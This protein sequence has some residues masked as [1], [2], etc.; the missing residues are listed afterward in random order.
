LNGKYDEARRDMNR[1]M[2]IAPQFAEVYVS[3]GTYI[4][5]RKTDPKKA[6]EAFDRALKYS[7]EY[8]L[9]LNGKGGMETITGDLNTAAEHLQQAKDISINCLSGLSA[10]V[11]LNIAV[12]GTKINEDMD[13]RIAKATGI[14][15]GMT[16]DEKMQ[17]F[18]SL[19]L[20][21]KQAVIDSAANAANFNRTRLG[22]I[23][24][25][26]SFKTKSQLNG[27][28]GFKGTVPFGKIGGSTGIEIYTD[29]SGKTSYNVKNQEDFLKSAQQKYGLSPS[30][31]YNSFGNDIKSFI[32]NQIG[33]GSDFSHSGGVSSE[34]IGETLDVGDWK[35]LTIY[36]IVYMNDIELPKVK[37][38]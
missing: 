1:C 27:E 18:G 36:G 35:V 30:S 4:V 22:D 29:I 26:D 31:G 33:I 20:Q 32:N 34:Q 7:P 37:E 21:Q 11:N 8:V 17:K 25:P 14:N 28:I 19:P 10:I 13:K 9:A 6:L 12:L 2:A 23:S 38:N 5:Q 16:L 24:T 15:P 3:W